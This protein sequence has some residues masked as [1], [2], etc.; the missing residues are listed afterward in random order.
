MDETLPVLPPEDK[1]PRSYWSQDVGFREVI[2]TV[3]SR[4]YVV[5][6]TVE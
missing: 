6:V 1:P 3:V 4:G 2:G 5:V